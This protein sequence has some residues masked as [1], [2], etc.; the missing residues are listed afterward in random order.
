MQKTAPRRFWSCP[1]QTCTAPGTH[2]DDESH[3]IHA[4]LQLL[5]KPK[6]EERNVLAARARSGLST[7]KDAPNMISRATATATCRSGLRG[8]E[9]PMCYGCFHAPERAMD[10]CLMVEVSQSAEH[11]LLPSTPTTS[12]P[13][14]SNHLLQPRSPP[15]FH[16]RTILLIL[17]PHVLPRSFDPEF[18]FLLL[19]RFSIQPTQTR[20]RND[21]NIKPCIAEMSSRK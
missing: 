14:A 13:P 16:P 7:M 6:A 21:R 8:Q 9:T 12:P 3:F 11:Y 15:L 20:K 17:I 5:S 19:R 1:P 4:P 18:R 2:I 10:H